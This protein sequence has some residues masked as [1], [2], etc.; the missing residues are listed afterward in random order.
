MEQRPNDRTNDRPIDRPTDRPVDR[1]ADTPADRAATERE[2]QRA[3][4]ENDVNRKDMKRDERDSMW[5]AMGDVRRRFDQLQ[6]QFVEEPQSA[7]R[8]AEELL[9]E[10]V[11]KMAKTMHEQLR[12]IHG[13]MGDGTND[14]ERLR[15]A[16]Q[17]MRRMIDSWENRTAA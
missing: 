10:T 13:E 16:M 14:T 5:P 11:D 7:V 9:K 12:G 1:P 3:M 8:K 4:R 15:R 17:R 2:Q 6:V